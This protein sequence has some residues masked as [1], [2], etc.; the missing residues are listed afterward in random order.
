MNNLPL[1][2]GASAVK[3]AGSLPPLA[4][5]SCGAPPRRAR[6][7][8]QGTASFRFVASDA[9]NPCCHASDAVFRGSPKPQRP[10][11]RPLREKRLWLS[12]VCTIQVNNLVSVEY[13]PI[14]RHLLDPQRRKSSIIPRPFDTGPSCSHLE[15]LLYSEI[16]ITVAFGGVPIGVSPGLGVP[17]SCGLA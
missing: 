11:L 9:G 6:G 8:G 17:S 5:L 14:R 1:P 12:R 2:R 7:D 13:S 10:G 3:N 4:P 15:D 16:E